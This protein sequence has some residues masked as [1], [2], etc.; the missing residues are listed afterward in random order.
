MFFRWLFW[1]ILLPLRSPFLLLRWLRE[2]LR[3]CAV[4]ELSLHGSVPDIS[5]L[6]GPFGSK[7]L[8]L[9]S[10]LEML[11]CAARDPKL[12]RVVVTIDEF[13]DGLARAEELRTA[14]A[15]VR[16]AGKEVVVVANHLNLAGYWVALGAGRIVLAPGGSLDI[17][18]IASQFTLLKGLLDKV[19][20]SARLLAKGRYKSMRELFAA[21]EISD[22]NRE[23]LT[24][25]VEDLY[26]HLSQRLSAKTGQSTDAIRKIIDR[27]PF[28]AQAAKEFGLVDELAY[29]YDLKQEWRKEKR[30][31][32]L[33]AARYLRVQSRS[34]YPKRRHQ[35]ALL[36]VEGG[37]RM[38]KDNYGPNRKRGT[39]ATSF[40]QAVQSVEQNDDVKAIL[41]RVNSPGGSA[42]ASDLMW[43]ALKSAKKE[44]P[45]FVS[46]GNVA[47]SGGYYVSGVAGAR[48][49]ASPT[50]L[51]GS[52]GV[53]G[54]K[55]EA[56]RLM[57]KLG[58]AQE[59]IAIG[60]NANY[61]Q[62]TSDW[63]EQQLQK[64]QAEI[65]HHYEEFVTKMAL[66]RGLSRDA[67][68]EVAQGRVWTGAQALTHRLVDDLGGLTETISEL[69]RAIGVA[70]NAPIE[71]VIADR[72]SFFKRLTARFDSRAGVL[73]TVAACGALA[74]AWSLLDDVHSLRGERVWARLP[75]D[76]ELS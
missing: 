49:F 66:G 33:P 67:L 10:I 8:P 44:R 32:R 26:A 57:Q 41:L 38:G 62:P 15:R 14:L 53:V 58:I 72:P 2:R 22:A 23:M 5:A 17:V 28:L 18:G 64:V 35:V 6:G 7:Q 68:H 20:V 54:G 46:M 71:W 47:A 52:I 31:R 30:R 29:P 1:L 51:T 19:G 37:I 70:E 24:A 43:H 65:D 60:E 59:L 48:I 55:F 40:L 27:G 56:T 75:F 34:W 76:I 3:P 45:L 4:V 74:P 69:R 63:S 13:A 50:T 9:I 25:L 61:Y 73:P 21:D 42:L 39:G 16:D 36:E 11:A 12:Q